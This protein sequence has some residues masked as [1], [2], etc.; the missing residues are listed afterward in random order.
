[1]NAE[2]SVVKIVHYVEIESNACSLLTPRMHVSLIISSLYEER[3]VV[4]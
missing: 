1:M 4:L 2:S 3:A